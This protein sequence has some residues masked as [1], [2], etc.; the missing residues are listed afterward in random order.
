MTPSRRPLHSPGEIVIG[1]DVQLGANSVVLSPAQ[2]GSGAVVAANAV[3]KG[4]VRERTI[5]KGLSL[6]RQH[7]QTNDVASGG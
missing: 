3:V 2:I 5:Y 1:S 7:G 6:A 4:R